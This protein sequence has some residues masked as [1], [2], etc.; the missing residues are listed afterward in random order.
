MRKEI[1]KF[2]QEK[3][4]S[5]FRRKSSLITLVVLYILVRIIEGLFSRIGELI[6]EKGLPLLPGLVLKI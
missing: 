6:T 2:I 4:P 1:V 3:L 5:E